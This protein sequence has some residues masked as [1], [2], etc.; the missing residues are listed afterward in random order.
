VI[1]KT[2]STETQKPPD[3]EFQRK[4]NLSQLRDTQIDLIDIAY[5]QGSHNKFIEMRSKYDD[6]EEFAKYSKNDRQFFEDL[7]T[8][9]IE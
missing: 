6:E 5:G 4:S 2:I 7:R 8:T 9:I 3:I 1:A